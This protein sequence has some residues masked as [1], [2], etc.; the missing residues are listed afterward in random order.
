[1]IGDP[2]LY[3]KIY[4]AWGP[5]VIIVVLT[6]NCFRYIIIAYPNFL[7]KRLSFKER[8]SWNP[9]AS[10]KSMKYITA[11][12]MY[13]M[14]IGPGIFR[15]YVWGN[16]IVSMIVIAVMIPTLLEAYFNVF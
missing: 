12:E 15:L 16:I 7:K 6:A 14:K 4:Q 2:N 9:A 3:L 13:L 8:V 10:S 11:G 1:M 5:T